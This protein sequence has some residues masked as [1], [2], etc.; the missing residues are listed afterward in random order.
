MP[1]SVS[2]QLVI[3]A[4]GRFHSRTG[5]FPSSREAQA[6]RSRRLPD[7]PSYHQVL[8]AFPGSTWAEIR[9]E[10]ARAL[11]IASGPARSRPPL[12][13]VA[14]PSVR[15]ASARS[16]GLSDVQFALLWDICAQ[17]RLLDHVDGRAL[18]PL[19]AR[20]LVRRV[21]GWVQETEAGRTALRQHL[22]CLAERST[23]RTAPVYRAL[24]ELE[25]LLIPGAEVRIGS[26]LASVN[27]VVLGFYVHARTVDS[28]QSPR[29][30]RRKR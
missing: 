3:A 9:G 26:T 27:D 12:P 13:S 19:L 17:D 6:P 7:I 22:A 10:A 4:F 5:R 8:S 21:G 28:A 29:R 25:Q 1:D 23:G 14:G 16:T 15:E 20:Q 30:R 11:G 24:L 2:Q 18:R